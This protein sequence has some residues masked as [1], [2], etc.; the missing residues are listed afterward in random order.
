MAAG[1]SATDSL[2]AGDST[3]GLHEHARDALVYLAGPYRSPLGFD[4]VHRNIQRARRIA[5]RIWTDLRLPTICPHANTAF[6]DGV[7]TDGIFLTGDLVMLR[8]CDAIVM[9]PGW[10]DSAG[11]T[12]ELADAVHHGLEH[13]A[14]PDTTG[15][16][17]EWADS[18]PWAR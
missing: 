17:R 3:H 1:M 9:M 6:M 8:R 12:A 13:F 18:L 16:L 10:E 5:R 2:H 11:A 14:W 15:A 4:G 7:G